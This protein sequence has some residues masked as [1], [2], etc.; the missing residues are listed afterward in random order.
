MSDKKKR[1]YQAETLGLPPLKMV[2]V[3]SDNERANAAARPSA[4][5]PRRKT[6]ADKDTEQV[7]LRLIDYIENEMD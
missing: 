3:H 7:V 5:A 1:T 4:R 2:L 6:K